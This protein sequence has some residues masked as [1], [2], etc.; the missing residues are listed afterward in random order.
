MTTETKT[1]RG[2][3][4]EE[5]VMDPRAVREVLERMEEEILGDDGSGGCGRSPGVVAACPGDDDPDDPEGES[6]MADLA[7]F[8]GSGWRVVSVRKMTGSGGAEDHRSACWRGVLGHRAVARARALLWTGEAK[9]ALELLVPLH[10]RRPSDR[11]VQALLCG[12]L[13]ALGKTEDDFPWTE[14]PVLVRIDRCLLDHLAD[15]LRQGCHGTVLDLHGVASELGV[16]TFEPDDLH[17]ALARDGRFSLHWTGV[18]PGSSM[19]SR[20]EEQP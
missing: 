5:E 1:R 15:V 20:A 17:D 10:R 4:V 7:P 8:L 9:A 14:R 3:I 16:T 6:G 11:E 18:S 12:A 13:K 19:V 2:T